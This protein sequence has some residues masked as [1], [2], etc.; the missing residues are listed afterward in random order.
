MK[1]HAADR[2]KLH[3]FFGTEETK[4]GRLVV[5]QAITLKAS[6]ELYKEGWQEKSSSSAEAE[7]ASLFDGSGFPSMEW[8]C[9]R[10]VSVTLTQAVCHIRPIAK[11]IDIL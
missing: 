10:F 9:L 2:R 8:S 7:I 4:A 1:Q 3:R 6:N 11:C 5:V